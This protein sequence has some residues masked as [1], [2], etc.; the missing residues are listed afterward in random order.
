MNNT[1]QNMDLSYI[2][3]KN[4]IP[5][6]ASIEIITKCNFNC[7]HCYIPKHTKVMPTNDILNIVDQLKELG[8]VELTLTGGEI[9]VHKDILNIIRYIRKKGIRLTLFTNISLLTEEIVEELSELCINEISTTLFSLD[10]KINDGITGHNDSVKLILDNAFLLKKH[11]IPLDIKVPVMNLNL[12]EC[13][14]IKKFCEYHGFKFD[15]SV[16]ITGKTNGDKEPCKYRLTSSEMKKL[17]CDLGQKQINTIYFDN[18][19]PFC[20][21]ILD[22]LHIDVLGN[23]SP[24]ISFPIIYRNIYKN[25]LYDI[26]H[27][28]QIRNNLINLRKSQLAKCV[29]CSLKNICIRC[30]GLA[31]AEDNNIIGCSYIDKSIAIARTMI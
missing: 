18:D 30:P 2:S 6:S 17:F 14:K 13:V 7:I 3:I 29:N 19:S 22:S 27:K 21:A 9:F 12:T 4:Q 26:W 28:S 15:Y 16:A 1:F 23:V 8:I 20:K 24:C 11:N 31:F 5:Y 25:T 10:T